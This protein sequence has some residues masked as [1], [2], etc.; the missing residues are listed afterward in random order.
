MTFH[1]I[2][3]WP[4]KKKNSKDHRFKAKSSDTCTYLIY[5]RS[6]TCFCIKLSLIK[7]SIR[8]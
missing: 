2:F 8:R 4:V 5:S 1:M 6:I 7:Q 3:L